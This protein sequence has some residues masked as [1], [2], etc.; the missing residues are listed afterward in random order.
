MTLTPAERHD[1]RLALLSALDEA[2]AEIVE[3]IGGD[4]PPTLAVLLT[5]RYDLDALLTEQPSVRTKGA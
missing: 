5:E 4:E 1:H 3:V 2:D